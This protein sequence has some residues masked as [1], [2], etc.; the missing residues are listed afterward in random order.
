MKKVIFYLVF[1]IFFTS[2][3]QTAYRWRADDGDE[4][5]A[6]WLQ[7]VNVPAVFDGMG[8]IRLRLQ[9]ATSDYLKKGN[10]LKS[11]ETNYEMLLQSAGG[12]SLFYA[13]STEGPWTK[14]TNDTSNAFVLSDSP[15]LDDK[16]L[17][18]NQIASDT[19]N[20]FVA[21]R[22]Y[23]STFDD[24]LSIPPNSITEFEWSFRPTEN[25]I[26][27]TYYFRGG[28][29][30]DLDGQEILEDQ[31]KSENP[32]IIIA[33]NGT[34]IYIPEVTTFATM[35]Y[36]PQSTPI[37][38]WTFGVIILLITGFIAVRIRYF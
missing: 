38:Y 15:F 20:D 10:V 12:G 9:F 19:Q 36:S 33:E 7:D 5:S 13:L 28:Q 11:E 34:P 32:N 31:F 17:T 22:V 1:V 27:G 14:I 25:A 4:S 8:N 2:C 18:T 26:S 16:A 23:T 3:F 29:E 35:H 30:L 37:R 6:T 21:G 24:E